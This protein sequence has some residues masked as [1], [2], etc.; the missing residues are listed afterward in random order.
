MEPKNK[1]NKIFFVF[2][3]RDRCKMGEKWLDT[4]SSPAVLPSSTPL[5]LQL[6]PF[7]PLG[8]SLVFLFSL[9]REM[10][11][12]AET[13]GATQPLCP[14][15]HPFFTPP[16]PPIFAGVARCGGLGWQGEKGRKG[17]GDTWQAAGGSRSVGCT[18]A[19]R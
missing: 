19:H 12:Q 8:V 10:T 14:T 1:N 13:D 18:N 17:K 3:R 4:P 16:H 7:P 15:I 2:Y 6:C 11:E 9:Q 5:P